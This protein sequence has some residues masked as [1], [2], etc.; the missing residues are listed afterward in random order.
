MMDIK[1]S[2]L[3]IVPYHLLSKKKVFPDGMSSLYRF[4]RYRTATVGTHLMAA[5]DKMLMFVVGDKYIELREE[6]TFEELIKDSSDDEFFFLWLERKVS[7]K[8]KV[9][10]FLCKLLFKMSFRNLLLAIKP[11]ILV[12]GTIPAPEIFRNFDETGVSSENIDQ[13]IH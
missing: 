13:T 11:P 12:V 5:S 9:I 8:D 4:A 7:F 2:N 3:T 10:W 1:L 6:L